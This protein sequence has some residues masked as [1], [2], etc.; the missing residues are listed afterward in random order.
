MR[1]FFRK[2][3]YVIVLLKGHRNLL[4]FVVCG[5]AEERERRKRGEKAR[6][7]ENANA[8]GNVQSLRYDSRWTNQFHL[9]WN[10]RCNT[11]AQDCYCYID[12]K[13][14]VS[15]GS[16]CTL[17]SPGLHFQQAVKASRRC[18]NSY[19]ILHRNNSKSFFLSFGTWTSKKRF[20][21]SILRVSF[22]APGT[23]F[24]K[25]IQ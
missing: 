3:L 5:K 1:N 13:V 17:H 18:T 15:S 23:F 14:F 11:L 25:S 24:E 21:Y 8:L 22:Y 20:Y 12:D 9:S 19:S 10:A 4:F 6:R 16:S 2:S 7:K